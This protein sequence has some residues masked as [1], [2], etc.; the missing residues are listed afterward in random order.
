MRMKG[1]I[2]ILIAGILLTMNSCKHN[3]V[4]PEIQPGSR[5]YVWSLDTLHTE[6][7]DITGLWGSS[8]NDVWAGGRGGTLYNYLWHFDGKKWTTWFDYHPQVAYCTAMALFGFASNDVWMGGQAISDPGAGLSHWDGNE[9]G[10]YFNYNPD[11]ELSNF[12]EVISI[13]G[14]RSDDVYAMGLILYRDSIYS[15]RGFIL[16]YNGATW[17]ELIKGERGHQ[18][19]FLRMIGAQ[20]KLYVLEYRP[21][22]SS[23]DSSVLMLDELNGNR[24]VTVYSD[25]EQ[26][27]GF[28]SISAIGGTLYLGTRSAGTSR[29]YS[30]SNGALE[31]RFS[32]A[33]PAFAEQFDGRNA[34]DIFLFSFD[35]LAHFNGND[36]AYLYKFPQSTMQVSC[37][38]AMFD[39]E[40]FLGIHNGSAVDYT[41]ILHGKR[42]N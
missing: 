30:F 16:H 36:V 8:P 12:A 38:P 17:S 9:W 18:F 27:I 39:Q 1:M 7:N 3:P 6:F 42:N 33:G 29:F 19:H 26:K 24:L 35:G 20:G 14:N 4:G 28:A 22:A 25:I 11:P 13:W 21:N 41:L 23:P 34:D 15:S 10:K 31:E 5:D 2:L 32:I 37:W 40:I